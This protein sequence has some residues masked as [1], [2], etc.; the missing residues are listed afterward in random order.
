MSMSQEV[1]EF[2]R[3]HPGKTYNN[4]SLRE[5]LAT[6][7]AQGIS[8]ALNYL[9]NNKEINRKKNPDGGGYVYWSGTELP[10]A[11]G[12][13]MVNG[14]DTKDD[15]EVVAPPKAKKAKPG[16]GP[17][18]SRVAKA[19]KP[20]KEKKAKKAKRT[21]VRRP[22]QMLPVSIGYVPPG[23]PEA[24]TDSAAPGIAVFGIRHDGKLVIDNDGQAVALAKPEVQRLQ[25]F[26]KTVSPLWS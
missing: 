7:E 2:L 12:A 24:P 6:D 25:G 19:A 8:V 3:A 17:K 11:E 20:K 26:L 23:I 9:H 4:A 14:R 21:P 16:R 18:Q 13:R 15:D 1:R 22:P 5:G 10:A